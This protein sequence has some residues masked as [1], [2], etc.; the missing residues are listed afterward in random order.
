M[1]FFI[2]LVC[3]DVNGDGLPNS[4]RKEIPSDKDLPPCIFKG[5]RLFQHLASLP[6][7]GAGKDERNFLFYE[8]DT[9]RVKIWELIEEVK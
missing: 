3:N 6:S 5:D 9:K 1:K 7:H 4:F 2:T 8:I